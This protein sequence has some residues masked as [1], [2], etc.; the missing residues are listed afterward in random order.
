MIS[1]LHD[2]WPKFIIIIITVMTI[3]IIKREESKQ[4]V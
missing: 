2:N 1:M 3:I 4:N